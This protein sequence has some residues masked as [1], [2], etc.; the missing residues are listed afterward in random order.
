[1]ERQSIDREL[2]KEILNK[3]S[4]EISYSLRGYNKTF[5]TV[6]LSLQLP[7]ILVYYNFKTNNNS[8]EQRKKRS[9]YKYYWSDNI[10]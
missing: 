6:L 1:M 5:A 8:Q 4:G 2:D 7:H 9:I 10:C 3:C